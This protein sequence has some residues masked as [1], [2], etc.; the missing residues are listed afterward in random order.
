MQDLRT[1]P[2]DARIG[3]AVY[4]VDANLTYCARKSPQALWST[5]DRRIPSYGRHMV[6]RLAFG[7]SGKILPNL[8]IT[9]LCG[10]ARQRCSIGDA[11][12][13]ERRFD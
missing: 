2:L 10:I 6:Q 5:G 11:P 13:R 1:F 3:N 12:E 9:A 4:A 7:A 8:L